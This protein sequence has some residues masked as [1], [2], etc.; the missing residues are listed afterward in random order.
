MEGGSGAK[1]EGNVQGLEE[2]KGGIG[3]GGVQ[4]P[5]TLST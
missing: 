3:G 4:N 5:V 2:R 1:E